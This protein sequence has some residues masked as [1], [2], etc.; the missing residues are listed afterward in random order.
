MPPYTPSRPFRP[1]RGLTDPDAQT[2]FAALVRQAKVP[3]LV[4]HRRWLS[5]GDFVDLDLLEASPQSPLL[6]LLH[7][8]EGSSR[9]G[10]IASMLAGAAAR[11]WGAAALNFRSCSGEANLLARFYHSGETGDVREVLSGLRAHTTGP[12]IAAGF[13]LGGNVLLKLL[14]E[15]GERSPLAAAAAVSTPFDLEACATAL[16]G[17]RGLGR[18]Y[19]RAFLESLK[20]KALSKAARFPEQLD[21]RKIASARTLQDFDDAVTARLHGFASAHDYYRQ[22]SSGP[23]LAEIRRPTLLLN[24]DDDPMVPGGAPATAS[25][26]PFLHVLRVPHGGHV[27]FV[28]GRLLRPRWWAESELMHFFDGQVRAV[29]WGA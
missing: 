26:Q 6:L 18:I 7:G 12:L 2:L 13:S 25:E 19:R 1:A 14:A 21:A 28:E 24:A 3:G 10:Y 15:D 22:S 20:H 29:G 9:S 8:L 16:D 5:D 4:R 17:A 23:R 27:G 11:G